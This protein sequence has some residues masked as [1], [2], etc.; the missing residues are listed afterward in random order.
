[1]DRDW[2][3]LCLSRFKFSWQVVGK[4]REELGDIALLPEALENNRISCLRRDVL[5]R[6][7]NINWHDDPFGV[8][9]EK[10]IKF[11]TIESRM[12]PEKLKKLKYPPYVIYYKGD[13]SLA[14]KRTCGI[15]GSRKCTPFG[16]DFTAKISS[17]LALQGVVIVS[18]MA[19]GID[20]VAHRK[21][22]ETG[23]K[24]IAVLGTSIDYVYPKE[25]KRLFE[26]ICEEH[27]VISPFY[28]TT[29][30]E[31]RNFPIRSKII[32]AI[33]DYLV[34]VEA[35]IKSGALITAM[36][37]M[38][39]GK[40]VFAVPGR[41]DDPYHRGTNWI[42]KKGALLLDSLEDLGLMDT[43]EKSQKISEDERKVLDALSSGSLDLDS[44]SQLSGIDIA[45]LQL[46]LLELEIK[47]KV[48]KL[49]G[50]YYEKS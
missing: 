35:A 24:T 26:D 31:K 38:S 10:N 16:R 49:A 32:A 25:N 44:I 50:G 12:Y 20:T 19:L 30:P 39:L 18:G 46:V 1:M 43:E 14:D 21:A 5:N 4:I 2:V 41:P 9:K 22:I 27:L 37:A 33:S 8:L 28:P 34:V 15:V 23:G 40:R 13:L 3:Y 11:V 7:K 17:S 42:I 45:T 6:L 29:F 48:R 47:G 36:E